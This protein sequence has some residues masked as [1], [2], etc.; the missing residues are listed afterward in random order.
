MVWNF[1]KFVIRNVVFV[2]NYWKMEKVD[3]PLKM[4]TLGA[5]P[6]CCMFSEKIELLALKS[7]EC[8]VCI[9]NVF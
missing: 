3:V 1:A 5:K 7:N 8:K 4:L 6:A 2:M 9:Q